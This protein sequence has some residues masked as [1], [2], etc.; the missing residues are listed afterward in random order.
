[1]PNGVFLPT[2]TIS[3]PL[4]QD[5][6]PLYLLMREEDWNELASMQ[7]PR[8][9]HLVTSTGKGP[10]KKHPLALVA[11]FPGK[12]GTPSGSQT[13]DGE[14]NAEDQAADQV[15]DQVEDQVEDVDGESVQ[16]SVFSPQSSKFGELPLAADEAQTSV[17]ND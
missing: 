5:D 8:L 17:S 2:Q 13:S 10:D 7:T 1:M 6:Q 4:T 16:S 14:S 15:G 9:E 3:P 11:V 12:N